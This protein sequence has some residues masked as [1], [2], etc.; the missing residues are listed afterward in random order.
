M[1]FH[2]PIYLA[3]ESMSHLTSNATQQKLLPALIAMDPSTQEVS[4]L[5]RD[6]DGD[7]VSTGTM[8]AIDTKNGLY[9][10]L[11]Q[12]I[13]SPSIQLGRFD[14]KIRIEKVIQK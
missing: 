12:P 7:F 14:E 4:T 2:G 13:N 11:L 9:F 8:G 6:T 3:L 5:F 10:T 1:L